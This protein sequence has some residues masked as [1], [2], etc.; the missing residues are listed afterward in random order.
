MENK[1]NSKEEKKPVIKGVGTVVR[2]RA[3]HRR[4]AIW[5]QQSGRGGDDTKGGSRYTRYI[6]ILYFQIGKE[7]YETIKKRDDTFA[8][9][10]NKKMVILVRNEKY[11]RKDG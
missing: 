4:N 7:N 5:Y 2:Q 8:G 9:I 6:T 10:K 1:D 3:M 11:S